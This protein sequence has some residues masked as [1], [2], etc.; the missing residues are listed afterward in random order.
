MKKL[1]TIL[2]LMAFGIAPIANA[3]TVVY[4][5]DFE[6]A[7]GASTDLFDYTDATQLN[8]VN[9]WVATTSHVTSTDGGANWYLD[10]SSNNFIIIHKTFELI[11]GRTYEFDASYIRETTT[12]GAMKLQIWNG[13]GSGSPIVQSAGNT[14]NTWAESPTVEFTPSV[15]ANYQFRVA[16]TWGTCTFKIDNY[17]VTLLPEVDTDNDGVSDSLDN[18]PSIAN[19]GQEDIDGDGVG[20]VC[21][22][23]RVYNGAADTSFN[24]SSNWVSGNTAD[25]DFST[26]I[27]DT[28]TTTNVDGDFSQKNII[29]STTRISDFTF[30]DADDNNT[31]TIDIN[32]AASNIGNTISVLGI[33]HQTVAATTLKIDSDVVVDNTASFDGGAGQYDDWTVFKI[34]GATGNILE[35]GENSTLSFNGDG[36]TGILGVGEFVF[37]GTIT[38]TETFGIGADTKATFGAT[39]NNGALTG[40]IT[41]YDGADVTVNTANGNK[42]STFKIQANGAGTLTVNTANVL[43]NYFQMQNDFNLELNASQ[44]DIGSIRFKNEGSGQTFN[45]KMGSGVVAKFQSYTEKWAGNTVNIEN[46]VDGNVF[47]G[48]NNTGF[49]QTDIDRITI[50][51]SAPTVGDPLV[52]DTNGSLWYTSTLSVKDH[53]AFEFAVYPNPV[54][55]V[56]T[57][58]TQEPL[59]KIEVADLLGRTVFKQNNVS[60]SVDVSSLNKGVY[61]LKLT[62]EKGIST[63]KI[64]KE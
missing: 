39:S 51:G 12:T 61:I 37:N 36:G 8:G 35:F 16:K 4:L 5:E 29:T 59:Q 46:F 14:S 18:C 63:K 48:T 49:A 33:N 41:L 47:F 19:A 17:K 1:Y 32:D 55:D 27:E 26:I 57:I 25:V 50:E 24:N 6:G 10:F 7:G 28:P 20:N 40:S 45:L 60:K 13:D 38:G 2:F 22:D 23:D 34:D 52:L 31:L 21:D 56:L 30:E 43:E 9:S 62:S 53:T 58:N 11:G 44:N 42:F 64:I 15:T 54:K 3:Q